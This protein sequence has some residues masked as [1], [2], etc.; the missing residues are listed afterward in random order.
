MHRGLATLTKPY[1]QL[2]SNAAIVKKFFAARPS[3]V[4]LS[5][6]AIGDVSSFACHKHYDVETCIIWFAWFK[7]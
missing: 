1:T 3:S 4:H 2:I 5:S 6:L 7:V